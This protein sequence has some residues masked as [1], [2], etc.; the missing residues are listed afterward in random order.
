MRGDLLRE[1]LAIDVAEEC[2]L[3]EVLLPQTDWADPPR[4]WP[5]KHPEETAAF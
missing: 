2:R 1:R 5:A 4:E 3:H